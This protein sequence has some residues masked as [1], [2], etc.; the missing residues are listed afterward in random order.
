MFVVPREFWL[1]HPM[2]EGIGALPDWLD[3]PPDQVGKLAEFLKLVIKW[4]PKINLVSAGSL[5]QAWNRHILDSAQLWTMV[6][7]ASGIWLDVG[8]GG[9]FPGLVIAILAQQAAPDLQVV[10][11]ESDRRKAVFLQE[12]VRLLELSSEVRCSRVEKLSPIGATVLTARAVASL[13][14]LL[15]MAERHLASTGVSLFP[16]GQR[17]LIELSEVRQHWQMQTDVLVSKTDND[18]A[19]LKIW[20]LRRA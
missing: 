10:L 19:V 17:H 16:K 2:V 15:P 6:P 8:S 7:A 3:A 11:V 5:A 4:N 20:D 9:G 12:A 1:P 18:A 13:A 14:D